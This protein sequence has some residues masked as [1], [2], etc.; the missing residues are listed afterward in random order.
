MIFF[1]IYHLAVSSLDL[2]QLTLVYFV[3]CMVYYYFNDQNSHSNDSMNP[4]E[5]LVHLVDTLGSIVF[6]ILTSNK[7]AHLLE[8]AVH[9]REK[10]VNYIIFF[11]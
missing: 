8:N 4:Y 7:N 6:R 2:L 3:H 11:S 9:T 10:K 5:I 1:T